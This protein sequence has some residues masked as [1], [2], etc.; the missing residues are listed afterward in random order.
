MHGCKI[1][2]FPFCTKFGV[3]K[4]NVLTQI[5]GESTHFETFQNV[6]LFSEFAVCINDDA[7]I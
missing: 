2:A 5:E 3:I 7:H 6:T 4:K 1:K